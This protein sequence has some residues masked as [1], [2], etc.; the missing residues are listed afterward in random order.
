MH[1][2]RTHVNPLLALRTGGC[3]DRWDETMPQAS[4]QR[5]L[6][7][8]SRRCAR[9]KKKYDELT[10]KVKMLFLRL[11][12]FIAPSKLKTPPIPVSPPQRELLAPS[13]CTTDSPPPRRPAQSPP[14]RRYPR[15]TK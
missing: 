5:L 1:W 7:R 10:Q 15:A 13:S 2:E 6:T 12:L 8:R 9:Q 11:F 4:R 3:N 14:W